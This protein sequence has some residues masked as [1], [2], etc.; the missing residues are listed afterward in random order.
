MK[1]KKRIEIKFVKSEMLP[2]V[3]LMEENIIYISDKYGIAEHKCICGCGKRVATPLS[4]KEWS[5]KI[6]SKNR[7]SMHPS[8]GNYQYKC[9]SHYIISKGG[10]NFV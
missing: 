1:T 2:S 5:Y 10:A 7:L 9:K 3:D 8:I 6:D 4:V